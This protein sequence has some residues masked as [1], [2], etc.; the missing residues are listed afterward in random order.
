MHVSCCAFNP[1]M[2]ISKML[3]CCYSCAT[4]L[5][6]RHMHSAA[7]HVLVAFI[8]SVRDVPVQTSRIPVECQAVGVHIRAAVYRRRLRNT[9]RS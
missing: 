6:S 5:H 1:V 8:A 3:I 2:T 4:L 9:S 7:L